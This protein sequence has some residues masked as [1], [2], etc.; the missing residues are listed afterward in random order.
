[1][2]FLPDSGSNFKMYQTCVRP[3]CTIA[4]FSLSI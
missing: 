2:T 3:K 4:Q 1:L